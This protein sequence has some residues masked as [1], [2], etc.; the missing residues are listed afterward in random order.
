MLHGPECRNY[1]TRRS[2]HG[3]S[4]TRGE[5]YKSAEDCTRAIHKR[6]VL[7]GRL[8]TLPKLRENNRERLEIL[9]QL[10]SVVMLPH[11]KTEKHALDE[12]EGEVV[13][14]MQ[15]VRKYRAEPQKS[16]EW[17]FKP[18]KQTKRGWD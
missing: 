8:R 9:R 12:W 5:I 11:G 14:G 7:M 10:Q 17:D 16:K 18:T 2:L 3:G 6:N 13:R 1:S 15:S 4:V